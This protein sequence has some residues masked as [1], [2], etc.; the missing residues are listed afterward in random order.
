[1]NQQF[2]VLFFL[3][4]SNNQWKG[5]INIYVR[6]TIEKKHVEWSVQKKCERLKWNQQKG[7]VNGTKMEVA[8][9]NSYLDIVQGRIFEIQ[10]E[11]ALKNIPLTA[12]IV[13]QK[14]LNKQ[15]ETQ[16]T[17]I[18]VYQYHNDQFGEL[19]GIE[20]SH[21]TYKK[22]K[23]ALT[24]ITNFIQWKFQRDDIFLTELN[25][26]FITDYEFYLKTIQIMQHNSAM[27]NIKKLKKI[28]RICV[29][30]QWLEKNPFDLYKM[31]LKQ[32]HRNFLLKNELEILIEK[33]FTLQRLEQVKDIFLFSCYTGLSYCDVIKLKKQ[34]INIGIDGELWVFTRRSKTDNDSRIPLLPVAKEILRKY[35]N[36]AAAIATENLLPQISNQK[37]NAYLK[38][39]SDLCGFNK[40]LTFHCARHTFATTITLSNGVPIETV[41]K[42]LGH[43]NL[44][45]TQQYARIL[46][47]KVSDD[48]QILQSKFA[49]I[50]E[51]KNANIR[52]GGK[53]RM[54]IIIILKS[55]R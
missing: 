41:G 26:Q 53:I 18:N 7:R 51:N 43:S 52:R 20:Y 37:L 44:R 9:I 36:H 42:M 11:Y 14:L 47:R 55:I 33:K 1:M 50:K 15:Q 6:I 2:K 54:P 10:K 19:A 5:P 12:E 27:N 22:F 25:H 16:H 8:E 31:R 40:E 21:G 32:T 34:D 24:S 13:K 46:D 3:K 4:G 17:L 35:E 49:T 29:A 45:T 39:I 28:I 30:N 48:M 23:S 38:E